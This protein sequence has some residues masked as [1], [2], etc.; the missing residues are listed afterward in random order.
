M[1]VVVKEGGGVS[2]GVGGGEGGSVVVK[3]WDVIVS[4]H[5][6]REH[7]VYDKTRAW[8]YGEQAKPT[9]NATGNVAK[10]C[11]IKIC[12]TSR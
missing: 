2:V 10:L 11:C 9:A 1:W 5:Q 3:R 6:S 7:K 8:N 12:D 4:H